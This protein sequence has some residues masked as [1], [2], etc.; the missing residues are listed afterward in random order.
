MPYME[1]YPGDWMKC[2][3][4][5]CLPPEAKGVWI[6]MLCF[7]WESTQRGYLVDPSGCAYDVQELSRM[8]GCTKPKLN[9]II[10]ILRAKKTFSETPEGII[11]SRRIVSKEKA[12]NAHR[13]C[14]KL[15]GRPKDGQEPNGTLTA[16]VDTDID[17]L[18]EFDI[19]WSKYPKRVGKKRALVSFKA[20]VK[21]KEA[22]A[23]L[24]RAMINY[25]K[26][27]TVRRGYIQNGSTWFNNW[28]DWVDYKDPK[29]QQG[30]PRGNGVNI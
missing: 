18:K 19:A 9:Q 25:Q 28:R 5:R 20:S 16:E 6:D 21:T 17:V 15:G 29:V 10:N 8:V 11:Y 7:M 27:D 26:C 30:D 2:P 14:G 1:F 12:K 23:E 24:N 22:L 3:E 4:V 13:E